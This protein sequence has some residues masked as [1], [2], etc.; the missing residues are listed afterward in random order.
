ML[1]RPTRALLSWFRVGRTGQRFCKTH[2]V[3]VNARQYIIS[4]ELRRRLK[5]SEG[6]QNTHRKNPLTFLLGTKT[7]SA[8]GSFRPHPSAPNGSCTCAS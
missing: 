7:L 8:F 5:Q 6:R 2:L 3:S 4:G 1:R